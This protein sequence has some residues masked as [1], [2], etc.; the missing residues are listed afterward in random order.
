MVYLLVVGWQGVSSHRAQ[1]PF[2]YIINPEFYNWKLYSTAILPGLV[3][4]ALWRPRP[5]GWVLL[6]ASLTLEI[7][8]HIYLILRGFLVVLLEARFSSDFASF[9]TQELVLLT[10]FIA[11]IRYLWVHKELFQFNA[12][13][14]SITLS[15][16]TV[17]V[18]VMVLAVLVAYLPRMEY[19]TRLSSL[20]AGV[21]SQMIIITEKNWIQDMAFSADG[22]YIASAIQSSKQ[23]NVWDVKTRQVVKTFENSGFVEAIAFSPDSRY[24]IAGTASPQIDQARIGMEVWDMET[25]TKVERFKRSAPSGRTRNNVESIDFSPGGT[26]V[27]TRVHA[28]QNAYEVWNFSSG[29]LVR[30]LPVGSGFAFW[31]SDTCYFVRD[32]K[33]HRLMDLDSESVIKTFDFTSTDKE[34]ELY[35]TCSSNDGKLVALHFHKYVTKDGGHNQDA[36]EVWNVDTGQYLFTQSLNKAGSIRAMAFSPDGR[37][38]VAGGASTSEIK[39]WDVNTGNLVKELENPV[40]R[41]SKLSF[42]RDG[43]KLVSTG[44]RMIVIWNLE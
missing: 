37:Y 40:P 24:I 31:L 16:K 4:V 19:A 14:K 28:D 33:Q 38:I 44:E 17:T 35:G 18:M 13:A 39:F 10:S 5:A 15:W 36:I 9:I 7:L 11:I 27:A 32:H 20:K 43:K 41:V 21:S 34:M 29:N 12:D 2:L 25:G 26:Y 3:T 30:T 23:I 6:Q 8:K 22:R 1:I 42:S